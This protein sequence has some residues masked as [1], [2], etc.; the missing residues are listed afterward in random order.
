MKSK[1]FKILYRLT[2]PGGLLLVI[3]LTLIK[4]G[5]LA[6]PDSQ[7]VRFFPLAVF[8]SGLAL[9]AY[10]R[11]SRIFFATLVLT[12]VDLEF[13]AIAPHVSAAV[14][15]TLTNALALLL[16]A[17][18]VV[19]AFLKERGIISYSGRKRLAGI[20]VQIIAVGALCLPQMAAFAAHLQ[21]EFVP[22]ILTSWS[23]LSQ[24][25]L[26]AYL[27]S[28]AVMTAL[29]IRRYRAVESSLL[30]A[31]ISSFVAFRMGAGATLAG[32][33]FATGGL[34]MIVAVIE[35]SYSM[36][37]LDELTQLPSRRALNE[38]LLKLPENFTI[39]M[40]DVDH[41]KKFNDT[42]G[43]EAGDQALRMVASRLARIAG[44]GKAYRYGGEEFAVLFPSR[45]AEEVFVYIDRM[46][47]VI[48][49][50]NFVVRGRDRR[51][52]S[53]GTGRGRK[54]QTSVT[55]SIGVASSGA[56]VSV[57]NEV[58]RVADQAL[59]RAK[60]RGRNCT[61]TAKNG[62]VIRPVETGMRIVSVS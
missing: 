49:Q 23:R 30:W 8:A 51:R 35:T 3:S 13:S 16:P 62:K 4:V 44:G 32:V 50:S 1:V 26:A 7:L 40:L 60:S 45:P 18:L 27:L 42:F 10:F 22:P 41:F 20:A 28:T 59:Y 58:L 48:E 14:A 21:T 25:A 29:L 6:D 36:A 17:N 39:A 9:S 5:V 43:H 31:L 52:G 57:P 46:R 2:L 61:V 53:N 15:A 55:V 12:L 19:M 38:A 34:A 37:Y 24:P 54:R 47:K 33:F 56:E 11:R